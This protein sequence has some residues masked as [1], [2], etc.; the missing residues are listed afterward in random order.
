LSSAWVRQADAGTSTVA[1]R[2]RT[3]ITAST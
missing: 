1:W 3:R 2:P